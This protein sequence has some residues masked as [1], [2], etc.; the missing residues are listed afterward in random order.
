MKSHAVTI[1]LEDEGHPFKEALGF[2]VWLLLGWLCA[3]L[4]TVTDDATLQVL[5]NMATV[6]TFVGAIIRTA[7]IYVEW[8]ARRKM[9]AIN[10]K[11]REE[12]AEKVAKERE[13]GERISKNMEDL[14]YAPTAEEIAEILERNAKEK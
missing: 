14:L 2:L 4:R 1:A 11:I 7:Y 13:R 6:L 5:A 3:F 8:K 9:I 12:K 10:K